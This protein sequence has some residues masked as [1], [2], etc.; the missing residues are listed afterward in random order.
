MKSNDTEALEKGMGGNTPFA[1]LALRGIDAAGV[2]T[3]S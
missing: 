2:Y 1:S 3:R